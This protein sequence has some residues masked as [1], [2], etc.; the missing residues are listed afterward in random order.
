MAED[1][2]EDDD[3]GYGCRPGGEHAEQQRPLGR[4]RPQQPYGGAAEV[5]GAFE[6]RSRGQAGAALRRGPPAFGSAH[7]ASS[8]L[9]WERTISR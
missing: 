7:A 3:E 2:R 5:Q 8:S 1:L 6:G 9:S 4:H